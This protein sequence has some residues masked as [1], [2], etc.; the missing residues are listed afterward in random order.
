MNITRKV[1]AQGVTFNNRVYRSDALNALVRQRVRLQ[2][3]GAAIARAVV[4]LGG[5]VIEVRRW[6]RGNPSK[7]DSGTGRDSLPDWTLKPR[8]SN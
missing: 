7:D 4:I 3:D 8:A 5:S 1:T 2:F 6:Q